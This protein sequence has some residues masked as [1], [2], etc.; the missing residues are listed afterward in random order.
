MI[1][2]EGNTFGITVYGI[3]ATIKGIP[4][5]N[6]LAA[7]VNNPFA[8]LDIADCTDHLAKGGIKNASYIAKIIEPMIA[9]LEGELDG[10]RH[11]C[12]GIAD[13]VFFDGAGNVQNASQNQK[14]LV[15]NYLSKLKYTT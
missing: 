1:I 7:G 12:T 14:R 13:L 5:I 9:N 2:S 3:G 10:N 8:L 4:L 6:V 11:K 15:L